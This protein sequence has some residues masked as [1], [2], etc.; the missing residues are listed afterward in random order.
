MIG[1]FYCMLPGTLAEPQT[2]PISLFGGAGGIMPSLYPPDKNLF[3][4]P[5]PLLKVGPA[6][7]GGALWPMGGWVS[8]VLDN[9]AQGTHCSPRG[10]VWVGGWVGGWAKKSEEAAT[11]VRSDD[12]SSASSSSSSSSSSDFD[13]KSGH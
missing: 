6:G 11:V 7:R 8:L 2:C 5:K 12:D 10:G 13:A 1:H 9:L 3:T 4:T